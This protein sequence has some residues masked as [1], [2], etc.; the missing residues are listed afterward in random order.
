[1]LDPNETNPFEKETDYFS[2]MLAIVILLSVIA[3]ALV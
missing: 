2:I 3:I 1:M